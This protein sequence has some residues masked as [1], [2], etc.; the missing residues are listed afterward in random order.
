MSEP[1][2]EQTLPLVTDDELDLSLLVR[3]DRY[4][5]VEYREDDKIKQ[6]R[7]PVRGDADVDSYVRW[8]VLERRI[9]EALDM[10]MTTLE[11]EEAAGD[12]VKKAL[13]DALD[14]V[15]G[16]L[17]ERT[18]DAPRP[19]MTVRQILLTLKW[20]AGD[21]SVAD[22]VAKAITAGAAVARERDGVTT[23]SDGNDD[24]GADGEKVADVP[25]ASSSSSQR[26]SSGS[27]ERTG[28]DHSG[29]AESLGELSASTSSTRTSD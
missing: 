13:E 14:E 6:R 20:L 4:L 9:N 5:T 10:P 7:L 25:L 24:G 22:A 29:G 18:P 2:R 16:L 28:G 12:V 23:P 15:H 1:E 8:V 27:D 17:R 21:A 19:L 3:S 26:P 11:E